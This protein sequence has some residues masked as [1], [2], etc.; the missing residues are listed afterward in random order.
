MK[1]ALDHRS[2]PADELHALALHPRREVRAA[3]GIG[4]EAVE[5]CLPQPLR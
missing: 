5:F 4:L 3:T 2:R 1:H